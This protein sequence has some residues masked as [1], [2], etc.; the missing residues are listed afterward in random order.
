MTGDTFVTGTAQAYAG[1]ITSPTGTNPRAVEEP[2]VDPQAPPG[3][4]DRS[5][6]VALVEEGCHTWPAEA[7]AEPV[8]EKD[9]ALRIVVRADGSVASAQLLGDPGR[10]FGAA[11]IECARRSRFRPQLDVAGKPV[12]TEFRF[13]WH[14]TR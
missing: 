7:E 14:F 3:E 6:R 1:G 4:P 10:A 5:R 13:V 9:V 12:Q 8:D 2:E 11:A